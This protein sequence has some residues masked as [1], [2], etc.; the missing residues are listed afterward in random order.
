MI[1]Y[2]SLYIKKRREESYTLEI[3]VCGKETLVI[4]ALEA[5]VV[6]P[7]SHLKLTTVIIWQT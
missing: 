6:I 5:T 3:R 7:I 1:E 4:R 2:I